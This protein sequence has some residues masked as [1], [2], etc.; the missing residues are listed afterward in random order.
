M[1]PELQALIDKY[2]YHMDFAELDL[3]DINRQCYPDDDA[4]IHLVARVGSP[5][6][7]QLLTASGARVNSIG[8]MGFTPLHYA[9]MIGRIEIANKLLALGADPSIRNEFGET[10]MEVAI[11]GSHADM[12]KILK[13]H[14]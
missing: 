1:E 12:I 14:Q 13:R 7:I 5:D 10:P 2:R 3:T 6:E 11:N 4:L 8:D 9:A